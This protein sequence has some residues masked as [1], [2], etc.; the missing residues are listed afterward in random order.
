MHLLDDYAKLN[1]PLWF[2]VIL[3]VVSL[4]IEICQKGGWIKAT[5]KK[6]FV[7]LDYMTNLSGKVFY[8]QLQKAKSR[9]EIAQVEIAK[10]CLLSDISHVIELIEHEGATTIKLTQQELDTLVLPKTDEMIP[11]RNIE[12]NNLAL[13]YLFT[14]CFNP[15][16]DYKILNTGLGGIFIGPFF[17]CIHGIDWANTTKSKYASDQNPSK[18]QSKFNPIIGEEIFDKKKILL[19]DD[20]C[21]TGA[22]LKEL[23]I[24]L[25]KKGYEVKTG[26]IQFNWINFYRVGIGEKL[27]ERFDP[28]ITDYVSPFNYPGHKLLDHAIGILCGQRDL[29]GPVDDEAIGQMQP[30][31]KTYEEYKRIKHYSN[32]YPDIVALMEKGKRYAEKSGFKIFDP[33]GR[34]SKKLTPTTQQFLETLKWYSA[35]LLSNDGCTPPTLVWGE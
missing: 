11:E 24:E 21:G 7:L 31:G 1:L 15:P 32:E 4:V 34:P 9:P 27:I 29:D 14:R 8:E 35:A 5:G 16:P 26:A 28:T 30:F 2:V 23:K 13:I 12:C 3:S 6:A 33:S 25:V 18:P 17:K 19:L 10:Q 20:N 22:T